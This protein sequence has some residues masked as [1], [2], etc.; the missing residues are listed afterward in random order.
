MNPS[1][2]FL[3]PTAASAFALGCSPNHLK[4]KRDTNGGFLVAGEDYFLGCSSSSS[5]LW[6]VP[7]IRE[8]F[9]KRGLAARKK[10][11]TDQ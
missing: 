8:K 2:D 7:S 6:N 1:K 3:L 10:A 5:I 9:H 11:N 4:R